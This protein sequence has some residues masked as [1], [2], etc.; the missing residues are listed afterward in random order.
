MKLY[1]DIFEDNKIYRYGFLNNTDFTHIKHKDYFTL[2]LYKRHNHLYE[3]HAFFYNSELFFY[4]ERRT[5]KELYLDVQKLL[6]GELYDVIQII[7]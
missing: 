2:K 7:T 1:I 6:Q 4:S 3:Y 5:K